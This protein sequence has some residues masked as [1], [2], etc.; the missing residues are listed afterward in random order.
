MPLGNRIRGAEISIEERKR[1]ILAF[2]GLVRR[3]ITGG[4]TQLAKKMGI[5]KTTF[6]YLLFYMREELKAPIV[7][8]SKTS[9]YVYSEKGMIV[10]GF[11]PNK[12]T[13]NM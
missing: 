4:A 10:F 7:F 1:L 9:G 12:N 11:V 6:Y 2:D 8:N 5:S 13:G 3:K